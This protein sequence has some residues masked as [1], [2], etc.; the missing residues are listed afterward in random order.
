[1]RFV[2]E[3]GAERIHIVITLRPPAEVLPSRWSELIKE[4]MTDSFESWLR[5]AYAREGRQL[6]RGT[7]RYLN[8]AGLVRRW[9]AAAGPDNVTVI[10][11]DTRDKEFLTGAFEQLL[12]LPARTLSD[13]EDG[14]SNR[15]LTIPEAEVVRRA[16]KTLFRLAGTRWSHYIDAFRTSALNRARIYRSPRPGDAR[17]PLP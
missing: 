15:S 12:G 5:R 8:Q 1:R 3:L 2:N 17:L 16:N 9:A 7:R 4:G 13:V 6:A 11:A 10:V 14:S